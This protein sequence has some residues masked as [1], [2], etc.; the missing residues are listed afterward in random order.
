[1]SVSAYATNIM[2]QEV[3]DRAVARLYDIHC[4]QETVCVQH[5]TEKP[6]IHQTRHMY[7]VTRET[8]SVHYSFTVKSN[9]ID[10]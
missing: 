8:L 3:V 1:M 4:N 6:N 10:P 9:I 2:G 7:T 5:F